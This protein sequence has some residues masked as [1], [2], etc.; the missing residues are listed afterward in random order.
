MK[1]LR[2]GFILALALFSAS[3][4]WSQS[5]SEPTLQE[6]YDV[7]SLKLQVSESNL[8]AQTLK[9]QKLQAIL[10][11]VIDDLTL[12]TQRLQTARVDLKLSQDDLQALTLSSQ[13]LQIKLQ[14]IESELATTKQQLADST[15]Q[16][17]DLRDKL[18]AL[19]DEL[20]TWKDKSAQISKL[21][22]G[23]LHDYQIQTA[24][25][26]KLSQQYSDLSTQYAKA[27]ADLIE[28]RAQLKAAVDLTVGLQKELDKIKKE[29][30]QQFIEGALIGGG[31]VA[32][33]GAV[34]YF[35]VLPHNK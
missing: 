27:L 6:R 32:V 9:Y 35:F 16:L 3:A 5:T 31:A 34:L 18:I 25:L 1:L 19:G 33:T 21:Y 14:D 30:T 12:A 22:D 15:A 10:P 26:E 7:L 4:L 11:T 28:V 24:K 2:N 13:S 8:Q 17:Q 20:Q 23:L 29:M